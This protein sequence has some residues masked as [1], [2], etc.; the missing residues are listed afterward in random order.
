M[1]RGC[2]QGGPVSPYLFLLYA[3]ILGIF[4]YQTTDIKC[5]VVNEHKISW[6]CRRYISYHWWFW[7][8][9]LYCPWYIR[10]VC[11]VFW[12]EN[13][14]YKNKSHLYWL[15]KEICWSLSSI[16]MEVRL[17]R[18]NFLSSKN[19]F[20]VELNRMIN[21]NDNIPLPKITKWSSILCIWFWFNFLFCEFQLLITDYFASIYLLVFSNLII[22]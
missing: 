11:N 2:R 14:Q 13:Q 12:F 8:L 1:H 9:S 5:I 17:E 20:S 18:N 22:I 16:Q 3:E 6:I 19:T 21:L 15:K 4:I 7:G 10:T